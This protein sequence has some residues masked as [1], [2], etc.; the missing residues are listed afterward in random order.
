MK[1][2]DCKVFNQVIFD[3]K[4]N[5]AVFFILD[6]KNDNDIFDVLFDCL[7]YKKYD[8]K[9]SFLK[10]VKLSDLNY[11]YFDSINQVIHY[12]VKIP[13]KGGEFENWKMSLK[14]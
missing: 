2:V 9:A 14:S 13:D 3:K 1:N 10:I 4:N 8:L 6:G 5:I 11:Y 7:F 12:F